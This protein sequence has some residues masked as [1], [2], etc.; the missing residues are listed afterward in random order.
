MYVKRYDAPI[1][2]GWN[3]PLKA[4]STFGARNISQPVRTLLDENGP[5]HLR[6]RSSDN[7]SRDCVDALAG[8]LPYSHDPTLSILT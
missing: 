8:F 3:I 4:S 1:T 6:S 2:L 7:E 5:E